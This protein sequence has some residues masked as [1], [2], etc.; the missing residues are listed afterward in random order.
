MDENDT[1]VCFLDLSTAMVPPSAS[2]MATELEIADILLGRHKVCSP[3]HRRLNR[4]DLAKPP[5]PDALNI[6]LGL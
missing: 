4:I 1:R 6:T 2:T 5:V 3:P